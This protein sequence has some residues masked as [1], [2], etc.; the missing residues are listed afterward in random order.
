MKQISVITD[1]RSGVLAELSQALAA[2]DV[3]IESIDGEAARETG[4]VTLTVDQYDEALQALQEAGFFAVSEDA[5]IVRLTDAPGALAR[6]AERFKTEA[7]NIKSLRI[8]RRDGGFAVVALVT[9]DNER[10]RL[11]VSDLLVG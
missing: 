9:E 3:N 6:V 7:I 4:V 10:A 1:N 11:L 8:L 2:R 5:L